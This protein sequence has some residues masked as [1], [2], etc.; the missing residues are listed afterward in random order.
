[1]FLTRASS[2]LVSFFFPF[3]LLH[4]SRGTYQSTLPPL[5]MEKLVFLVSFIYLQRKK[6]RNILLEEKKKS[7][8]TSLRHSTRFVMHDRFLMRPTL[9][10]C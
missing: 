3:F 7:V 5:S 6:E 2:S 1:M 10:K 9:K 8:H 4:F